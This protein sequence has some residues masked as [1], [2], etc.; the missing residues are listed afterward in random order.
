MKK[1]RERRISF[2]ETNA[3]HIY[4]WLRVFWQEEE[5]RFGG[6]IECEQIGQRLE[7]FIGP[8]AHCYVDSGSSGTKPV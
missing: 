2:N 7:R 5:R 8:S 4:E 3:E 6:C 1:T